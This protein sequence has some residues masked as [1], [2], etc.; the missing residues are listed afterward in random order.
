M[1]YL[2]PIASEIRYGRH[3]LIS[4]TTNA[5]QN[6]LIDQ[7]IERLN[8]ILPFDLNVV[9][10]KGSQHYIDLDKFELKLVSKKDF[11]MN[12]TINEFENKIQHYEVYEYDI[13]VKK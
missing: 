11:Y 7:E 2:L 8:E 5:L 4:T 12:K 10:L 3:F 6:Q 1:G 9:S 13:E